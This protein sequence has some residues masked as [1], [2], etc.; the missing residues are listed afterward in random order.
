MYMYVLYIIMQHACTSLCSDLR[1]VVNE[2]LLTS[3]VEE[4]KRE[5]H[6]RRVSQRQLQAEEQI[7]KLEGELD[8]AQR[9]KDEEVSGTIKDRILYIII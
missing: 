1:G 4:L 9:Q 8:K 6:L 7:T 5:E 3:R 2:R